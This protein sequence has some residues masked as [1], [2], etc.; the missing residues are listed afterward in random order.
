MLVLLV[1]VNVIFGLVPLQRLDLTSERLYTL[2][3]GTKEILSGLDTDVEIRFYATRDDRLMPAQ[4]KNYIRHVEDL[5]NEYAQYANGHL[6]ITKF[7]PEPDSDA[8]DSAAMDGVTGQMVSIGE[9]IYLGMAISML[10]T[11][12]AIPFLDP[13]R[14]TLLEYDLTRAITQVVVE[15]KAVIGV[16]SALPV[17]GQQPNPMMMQMGQAQQQAPWFII[18]QLQQD[19]EVRE[20]P[21]ASETIDSDLDLLVLIHPKDISQAAQ[22]AVDQYLLGG[23]K[24]AA[25]LD[26]LAIVDQTPS[27]NGNNMMGPPPSSSS[28]D[29]L[30]AAWGLEFDTSKVVA[31]RA[32]AR[33]IAFQR[34]AQPQM[35]PCF[36]FLDE[37]GINSEDV[38]TGQTDQL[39]LPF[40][41]GFTGT[42]AEGLEKKVLLHSTGQSQLVD[43][44]MARLSGEQ[45]LKDFKP[46]EKEYDLAMRLT[47]QFK[48]AFPDGK[49][50][51]STAEEDL[52]SEDPQPPSPEALKKSVKDGAVLLFADADFLFDSF[53][54]SQ[55]NFL[56]AR[57]V[58]LLNGNIPLVQASVEYMAGDSRLISVRGRA[59]M[60]RPFTKIRQMQDVARDNYQA[61]INELEEKK[62]EA[63]QKINDIQRTRKDANQGQRFVLTP[64]QQKELEKLKETNKEVAKDLKEMRRNLRKDVDSLQNRLRW[65]NIAAVPALV[66]LF[67]LFSA[68]RKSKKTAAR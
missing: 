68:Y 62:R 19:F 53:G 56:G 40:P 60:N 55:Q 36:L 7:N 3:K 8:A 44:F 54:V 1:I 18:S 28:L 65:A 21:L 50:G 52:D 46:S 24:V 59:T 63:E 2:S 38:V 29:S 66:T 48:T 67:G 61:K 12:V 49:P 58:Q 33:E 39:M 27:P 23:G 13:Q 47:G 16:M 34:G 4:L 14:E 43:A 26:P 32:F 42:P 30:L 51:A 37:Q 17:F 9:S 10:D 5:L 35:Q 64:E 31:D 6:K 22:F 25:F 45:V 20:V 15:D 57:M 11:T 41:G